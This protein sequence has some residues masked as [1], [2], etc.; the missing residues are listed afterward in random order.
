M[1]KAATESALRTL[2]GYGMAADHWVG[3]ASTEPWA[4][5]DRG[6]KPFSPLAHWDA[7]AEIG[8]AIP[9]SNATTPSAASSIQ[10]QK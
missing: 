10:K 8:T 9:G 6:W 3:P 5:R 2:A 1:F 7:T 4:V